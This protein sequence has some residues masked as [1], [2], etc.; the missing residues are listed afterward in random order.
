MDGVTGVSL[1][2][3]K[4]C[5]RMAASLQQLLQCLPNTIGTGAVTV[6]VDDALDCSRHGLVAFNLWQD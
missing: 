5:G 6:P 4:V 3:I 1:H 2:T